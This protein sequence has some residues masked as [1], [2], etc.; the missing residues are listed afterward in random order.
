MKRLIIS[1]PRSCRKYTTVSKEIEQYIL[2]LQGVDEIVSGGSTGVDLIAKQ[3]AEE[4]SI[5]Y[6]E[7]EPNWQDEINAAGMVRDMRMAEYGTHLLILS[8]G[9]TKESKNLIAEAKK[10]NLIVKTIGYVEETISEQRR[11]IISFS[12]A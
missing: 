3:Y 12:T 7:F 10:Q 9:K 6:K 4:H 11:G 1:G 5:P 8:N 2:E